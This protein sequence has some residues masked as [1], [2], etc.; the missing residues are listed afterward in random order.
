MLELMGLSAAYGAVRALDGVDLTVGA[1]E[2]VTLVGANGAGKTT[3]LMTICGRPHWSG[4]RSS[5][6]RCG[7]GRATAGSPS[8]RPG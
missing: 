6:R 5:T 2:I 7:H 1:G 8:S 4:P 3:L